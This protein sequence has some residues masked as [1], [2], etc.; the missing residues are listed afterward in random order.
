MVL[1]HMKLKVLMTSVALITNGA[2]QTLIFL[3]VL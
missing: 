3:D 1:Y 2:Q